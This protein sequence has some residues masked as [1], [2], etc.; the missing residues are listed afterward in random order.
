[1]RA[2]FAAISGNIKLPCLKLSDLGTVWEGWNLGK[3]LGAGGAHGD[4]AAN[5]AYKSDALHISGHG[6]CQRIQVQ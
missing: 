4:A 2:Y 1:M 5:A 3:G 6:T